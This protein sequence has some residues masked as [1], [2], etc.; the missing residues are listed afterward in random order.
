MGGLT[1]H[2]TQKLKVLLNNSSSL[3]LNIRSGKIS[4]SMAREFRIF[5]RFLR[6]VANEFQSW[7]SFRILLLDMHY[8]A[9]PELNVAIASSPSFGDLNATMVT[10]L[11][12]HFCALDPIHFS[13][14]LFTI[15]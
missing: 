6:A 15:I 8:W 12:R 13:M 14:I 3:P 9:I 1:S 5:Q 2:F 10:C 11:S 7:I 4:S